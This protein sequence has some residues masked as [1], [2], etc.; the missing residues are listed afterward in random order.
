MGFDEVEMQSK[1]R[2]TTGKHIVAL[3][4]P[5]FLSSSELVCIS[6]PTLA[7]KMLVLEQATLLTETFRHRYQLALLQDQQSTLFP[8]PPTAFT[9]YEDVVQRLVPYHIWQTYDE[10]LDGSNSNPKDAERVATGA[11]IFSSPGQSS[12]LY[13]CSINL[14]IPS[15]IIRWYRAC[16][17]TLMGRLQRRRRIKF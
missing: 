14:Y 13:A 15:N 11:L 7:V 16:A 6:G 10:E 4:S 12:K 2:T 5:P 1:Q 8:D 17:W 3:D 9:S